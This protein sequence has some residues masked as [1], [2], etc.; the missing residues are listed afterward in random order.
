MNVTRRLRAQARVETYLARDGEVVGDIALWN[1]PYAEHMLALNNK[2]RIVALKRDK[3]D[4]IESF[5]R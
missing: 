3:N 2:V 5:N 4:T 1:L